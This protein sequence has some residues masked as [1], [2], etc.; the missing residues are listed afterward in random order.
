MQVQVRDC[1]RAKDLKFHKVL[2]TNQKLLSHDDVFT[3]IL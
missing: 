2:Q 1:E 3:I